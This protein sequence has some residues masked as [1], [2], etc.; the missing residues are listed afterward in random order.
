M[1]A[2]KQWFLMIVALIT[3]VLMYFKSQADQRDR[4][5]VQAV[6]KLYD[7]AENQLIKIEELKLGAAGDFVSPSA[8]EMRVVISE[9]ETSLIVW[10][11]NA[12]SALRQPTKSLTKEMRAKFTELQEQGN[13]LNK[14]YMTIVEQMEGGEMEEEG[15]AGEEAVEATSSEE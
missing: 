9:L 4:D 3:G 11:E 12:G 8:A 7:K 14:Q 15:V 5:L 10:Q 6:Q 1:M 13:D 2:K